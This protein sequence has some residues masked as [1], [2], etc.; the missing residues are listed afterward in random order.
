MKYIYDFIRYLRV[1]KKDSDY[2]LVNYREDLMELYDFNTDLLN[3]DEGYV[4]E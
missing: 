4:S 2:T 1:V 3:I